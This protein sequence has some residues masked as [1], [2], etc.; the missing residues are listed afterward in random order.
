MESVF[1]F[2]GRRK[3]R[4]RLG[5][6][7]YDQVRGWTVGCNQ[8]QET[9]VAFT[10]NQCGDV[11]TGNVCAA[12][13]TN[14]NATGRNTAKVM[15]S[16]VRRLTPRECERLQ[17]MPDDWT[18]IPWAPIKK[19]VHPLKL[20]RD[21]FKY[22]ERGG[23][24][25]FFE[26]WPN[27]PDVPRYKANLARIERIKMAIAKRMEAIRAGTLF[28]SERERLWREVKKQRETWRE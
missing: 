23:E 1:H 8:G 9:C 10:Q 12:L 25:D 27:P 14:Q 16:G 17:G 15:A 18:K 2:A 24:K 6:D 5:T 19:G 26:I 22:R 21:Y 4:L 20:I 3:M 13:G 11:L 7:A 28:D